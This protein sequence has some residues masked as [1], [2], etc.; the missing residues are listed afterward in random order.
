MCHRLNTTRLV[1]AC[2]SFAAAI[3]PG[4]SGGPLLDSRGRLIGV[5]TVIYSPSGASSGVGF[6]IPADTVRRVVNQIIRHGRV[7]KPGLG[8]QCVADQT[9]RQMVRA[10]DRCA[11]AY[12]IRQTPHRYCR[13]QCD[14]T[15]KRCDDADGENG[16]QGVEGVI[17]LD[18]SEGGGAKSAG[19]RGC[20]RHPITGQVVLG[21]VITAVEG[22]AVKHVED[23]ISKVEE[24]VVGEV[25]RVSVTRSG[26]TMD[27]KVR[28]GELV[29]AASKL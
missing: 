28:L 9:A 25:V 21:D 13:V 26:A 24:R 10:I 18:V 19:L 6:A 23:L 5:N 20:A 3:N 11:R 27:V 22:A 12:S 29:N 8:V 16:A 15:C 4:N 1:S 14:T 2:V 17:V 7:I